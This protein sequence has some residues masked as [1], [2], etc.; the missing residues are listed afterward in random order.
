MESEVR[1]GKTELNPIQVA[2]A[3]VRGP[4]GLAHDIAE[5]TGH[6]K[7]ISESID[8]LMHEYPMLMISE[9]SVTI[10]FRMGDR[11]LGKIITG[12]TNKE[13]ADER[14]NL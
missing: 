11:L 2:Q 13:V 14:S 12:F 5:F 4:E 1:S 8:S 10:E 9:A 7:T 3:L 6:L